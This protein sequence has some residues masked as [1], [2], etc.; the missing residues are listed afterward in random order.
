[1]CF[2]CLNY[3]S[4]ILMYYHKNNKKKKKNCLIKLL[5]LLF[6]LSTQQ[7]LRSIPNILFLIL[8]S[9]E[10]AIFRNLDFDKHIPKIFG[11]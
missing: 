3:F 4:L 10:T 2:V 9:L 11:V 5:L 1:M 6:N 8:K 7:Y